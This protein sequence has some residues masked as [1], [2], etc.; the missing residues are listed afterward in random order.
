MD[1]IQ[2]KK[3]YWKL[4]AASKTIILNFFSDLHIISCN[5]F[6]YLMVNQEAVFWND[7]VFINN[8]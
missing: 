3:V 1:I 7:L 5:S 2:Y 6:F 8:R 4:L